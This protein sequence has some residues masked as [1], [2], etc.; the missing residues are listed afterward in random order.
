VWEIAKQRLRV[1]E[2][3]VNLFP[4]AW[5]LGVPAEQ[6][7]LHIVENARGAMLVVFNGEGDGTVRHH[8][9]AVQRPVPK[10]GGGRANGEIV[11]SG[12]A[13][14]NRPESLH[15]VDDRPIRKH[16]GCGRQGFLNGIGHVA[17]GELGEDQF[18]QLMQ[19]IRGLVTEIIVRGSKR[20]TLHSIRVNWRKGG[21]RGATCADD[22]CTQ[23]KTPY[24]CAHTHQPADRYVRHIGKYLSRLRKIDHGIAPKEGF[25][26]QL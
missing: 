24:Q 8:G 7:G 15:P 1:G 19:I 10:G 16:L 4:A 3:L 12:P 22:R 23:D 25:E 9:G 5:H 26:T 20:R 2:L 17:D 13:G 11:R 14:R 21:G 6:L 18:E